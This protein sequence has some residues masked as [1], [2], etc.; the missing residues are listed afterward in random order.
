MLFVVEP[1]CRLAHSW[2]T[3]RAARWSRLYPMIYTL[4][5]Q[6]TKFSTVD[7]AGIQQSDN[8]ITELD[9]I[10]GP[11]GIEG[12][13][14][15]VVVTRLADSGRSKWSLLTSVLFKFSSFMI[16]AMVIVLIARP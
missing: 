3:W 5:E 13:R 15:T 10:W 4:D 8:S 12:Q 2:A 9:S 14:S 7:L 1:P 11:S 6:Y 16:M